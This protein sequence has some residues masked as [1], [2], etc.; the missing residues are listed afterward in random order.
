M[1]WSPNRV[2]VPTMYLPCD[3]L[4]SIDSMSPVESPSL[5]LGLRSLDL[6]LP[7]EYSI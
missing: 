2:L 1:D 5:E 4:Y 7:E 6:P 3:V